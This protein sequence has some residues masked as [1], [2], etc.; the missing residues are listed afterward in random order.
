MYLATKC[1]SSTFNSIWII[2]VFFLLQLEEY[3]TYTGPV[4]DL[5]KPDQFMYELSRVPGYEMRLKSILFKANFDEKVDEL[6][7]VRAVG[8]ITISSV[9][10]LS[11]FS[12]GFGV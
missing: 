11:Y 2:D 8:Y 6:K 7:Q 5:S 4:D 9:F 10:M 1:D 3:N 12:N